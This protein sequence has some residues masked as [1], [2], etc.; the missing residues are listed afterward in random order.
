M[1]H[2]SETHGYPAGHLSIS[3]ATASISINY[4]KRCSNTRACVSTY[5][6]GLPTSRPHIQ[7]HTHTHSIYTHVHTNTHTQNIYTLLLCIYYT[8]TAILSG[9]PT[10]SAT[11]SPSRPTYLS[12]RT[13]MYLPTHT[14]ATFIHTRT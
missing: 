8:T 12:S 2:L 9:L 1:G 11:R 6:F 5:V 4:I 10:A 3:R 14:Y 7:T 13:Y